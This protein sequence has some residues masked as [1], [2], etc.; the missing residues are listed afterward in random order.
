MRILNTAIVLLISLNLF[1]QNLD[2]KIHQCLVSHFEENEIDIVDLMQEIEYNL[3]SNKVV[4]G[5]AESRLEKLIQMAAT[6]SIPGARTLKYPILE[7]KIN[8]NLQ[9]CSEGVNQLLLYIKAEKGEPVCI[10]LIAYKWKF[11]R[12]GFF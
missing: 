3:I 5:S 8:N 4:S 10:P 9:Y 2:N 11:W 1:S 6:G 7:L 12:A